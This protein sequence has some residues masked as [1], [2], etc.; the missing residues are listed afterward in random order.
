MLR[1]GAAMFTMRI[2][3]VI[4]ATLRYVF[5]TMLMLFSCRRYKVI[6]DTYRFRAAA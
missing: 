5:A 3:C 6:H 1:D 2:C 4:D